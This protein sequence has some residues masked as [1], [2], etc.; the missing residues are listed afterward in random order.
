M[1]NLI[2]VT[3]LLLIGCGG[4][5][6]APPTITGQWTGTATSTI[7]NG[8]AGLTANFAQG[9]TNA[10]GTIPFSGTIALTSSCL[11]SVTVTN[12][13]ITNGAFALSGSDTDGSTLTVTATINS[14]DTQITGTYLLTPGSVCPHDQ[15]TFALTK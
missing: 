12:G 6:S 2:L 11:T 4:G 15:G 7:G 10:N 9:A 14:Q 5:S 13:T 8:T 1:K 3:L